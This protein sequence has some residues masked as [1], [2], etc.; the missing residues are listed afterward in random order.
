VG[1]KDRALRSESDIWQIIASLRRIASLNLTCLFPGSARVRENPGSEI[2]GKISY[3]ED[4]GGRVLDLNSRGWRVSEIVHELCGG[5]MPIESI[6]LGHFSRKQ[7]VLSYL[8][9]RP[10]PSLVQNPA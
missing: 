7:L 1:G 8:R 2:E 6:T 3:L 10:V 9:N 4:L 5:P